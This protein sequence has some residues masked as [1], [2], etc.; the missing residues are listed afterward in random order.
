MTDHSDTVDAFHRVEYT[1]I[2]SVEKP[3]AAKNLK[4]EEIQVPSI[5]LDKLLDANGVT[6]IDFMTMDIEGAEPMALAGLDIERFQPELVCIE[7]KVKNRELILKYFADHG[8]ERIER[9]LE[10]DVAN[11]YFTP[12]ASR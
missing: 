8:Y 2:S 10:Y 6:K 5:T 4:S 3:A 7:S 1:D 11:W 9:Y 12:K